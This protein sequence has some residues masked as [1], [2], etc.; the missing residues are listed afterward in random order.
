V[1]AKQF[2]AGFPKLQANTIYCRQML[3][4]A[5]MCGHIA[6]SMSVAWQV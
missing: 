6:E 3:F 4:I 2:A 1:A 5:A